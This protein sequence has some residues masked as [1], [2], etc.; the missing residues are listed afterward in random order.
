MGKGTKNADKQRYVPRAPQTTLDFLE[1]G[2]KK[3]EELSCDLMAEEPGIADARLYGRP[4]QQQFGID[5]YAERQDESGIEVVSCKCYQ[6]VRKGQIA[7]WSTDFLKHWDAHWKALRVLSDRA[8]TKFAANAFPWVT[9]LAQKHGTL[10]VS[11]DETTEIHRDA[12]A[13]TEFVFGLARRASRAESYKA[14]SE[15]IPSYIRH[16]PALGAYWRTL[17]PLAM[18]ESTTGEAQALW[19]AHT[20]VQRAP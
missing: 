3:F 12:S 4:R 20:A 11:E 18:E 10:A 6:E 16:W 15:L 9:G 17:I 14:L 19:A 8:R 7:A 13:V 1:N 2:E 5:V